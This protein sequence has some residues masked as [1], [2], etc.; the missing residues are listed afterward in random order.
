M[1]K[2]AF[3]MLFALILLLGGCMT[4][5]EEHSILDTDPFRTAKPDGY[6]FETCEPVGLYLPDEQTGEYSLAA[7]V[8]I[9]NVLILE[10]ERTSDVLVQVNYEILKY[11]D[12]VWLSSN[13]I[14]C[15]DALG[16]PCRW[17]GSNELN[18]EPEYTAYNRMFFNVPVKGEYVEIQLYI[19]AEPEHRII[20]IRCYYGVGEQEENP[21]NLNSARNTV[22]I[23]GGILLVLVIAIIWL[24]KTRKKLRNLHSTLQMQA[25]QMRNTQPYYQPTDG[26][27][28]G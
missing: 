12:D 21:Q 18:V 22:L 7:S 9:R 5:Q 4:V 2:I 8:C 27:A 19:G 26:G 14:Q 15:V 16:T 24:Y 25:E 13:N 17:I 3:C 10:R 20:P 28:E 11:R 23:C 6:V 1:K